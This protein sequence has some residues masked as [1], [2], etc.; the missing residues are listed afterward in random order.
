MELVR[1]V[2]SREELSSFE[3]GYTIHFNYRDKNSNPLMKV[4]QF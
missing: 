3:I 4:Y 2:K 1:I